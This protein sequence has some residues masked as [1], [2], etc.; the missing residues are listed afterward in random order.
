MYNSMTGIRSTKVFTE[1]TTLVLFLFLFLLTATTTTNNNSNSNYGCCSAFTISTVSATSSSSSSSPI[2]SLGDRKSSN[3]Q[4]YSS[5]VDDDDRW[6]DNNVSSNVIPITILSGFLGSGKTTIL[7]H[8]LEN[9]S[10]NCPVGVVVNDVADVNIDGKLLKAVQQ[11]DTGDNGNDGLVEL[12]NGC[13]C[14]SLSDELLTSVSELVTLSDLRSSG[15]QFKHIVIEMSGVSDPKNIRNT[16][17]QAEELGMAL[18][19]RIRLDTM[20]TVIDSELFESYFYSNKTASR[21]ETPELYRDN[22]DD[23]DDHDEE[24]EWM[25]DIPSDLLNAILGKPTEEDGIDG[26][27]DLLVSQTETADVILLNKCDLLLSEKESPTTTTTE[28]DNNN[29]LQRLKDLVRALNPRPTTTIIES[30]YGKVPVQSI[31]G[32]ANGEG[33]T[34]SGTV[35]DHRDYVNNAAAVVVG[36]MDDDG[37]APPAT[38]IDPSCTDTSHSHSQHTS[39]HDSSNECN[40]TDCTDASHSHSHSHSHKNHNGGSRSGS[41]ESGSSG[42]CA[43]PICTDPT[44]D[45]SHSHNDHTG[46]AAT[47]SATSTHAGIGTFVYRARRPFHP[48]RMVAFLRKLPIVRGLPPPNNN[49]DE[50]NDDEDGGVVTTGSTEINN[51]LRSTLRSKG[52]V[53]CASSNINSMYWSH[54]GISFDYKCLGQWWAT[55]SRRMWP[56][57]VDEYVLQDYDNINH[58]EVPGDFDV[59]VNAAD[60]DAD[61]DA[62][63]T[64]TAITETITKTTGNIDTVGDRRQEIVFIGLGFDSPIKQKQIQD[65]LDHCLLTQDE[66][67]EYK[68]IIFADSSSDVSRNFNG[69]ESSEMRLQKRF[70][71]TIESTYVN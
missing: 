70:P 57:G 4:L 15:K 58:I 52:F 60:V 28:D 5:S 33:V 40:D 51:T 66:Y 43:D 39:S 67:D 47:T 12:E 17:Q 22:E 20:I 29:K 53:W 19:E 44:H 62:T 13:A 25:K 54:S 27:A 36:T 42:E 11:Q 55:V 23:E 38:C 45:H 9:K 65:T 26:V 30:T 34:Q 63:T 49:D 14:C 56:V 6:R 31:L 7:T 21:N 37:L 10:G 32:V 48:Q 18:M 24:E 59:T 50:E 69:V 1:T 8:I 71:S 46:T 16:F 61:V 3:S 68:S 35:D 64:T 2:T 41:N